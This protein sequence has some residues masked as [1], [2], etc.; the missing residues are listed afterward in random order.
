[1]I[2]KKSPNPFQAGNTTTEGTQD[3][4]TN[5]PAPVFSNGAG[6]TTGWA[7]G[8]TFKSIDAKVAAGTLFTDES[9]PDFQADYPAVYVARKTGAAAGET[10]LVMSA[11]KGPQTSPSQDVNGAAGVS[12]FQSGVNAVAMEFSGVTGVI[13]E[14][15]QLTT[16]NPALS[17]AGTIG[18][19]G[20]LQIAVGYM[21]NANAFAA[22][23][24]WTV[25]YM[26][27][28]ASG[29]DH[30]VVAYKILSGADQ[31]SFSNPLGYEMAVTTLNLT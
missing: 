22:S 6:V 8:S 11:Y 19:S 20:N 15:H 2:G 21:K 14:Q 16:A 29:Q 4:D 18:G 13:T 3:M 7:V 30:F 12:I 17:G 5:T 24:G 26:D 23:T 28:C 1:V 27:K 10:I 25:V 9:K 31:G